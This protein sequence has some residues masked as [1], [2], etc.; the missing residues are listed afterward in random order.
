M[1]L[2]VE[3][4]DDFIDTDLFAVSAYADTESKSEAKLNGPSDSEE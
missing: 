1:A 2:V 3:I 4:M